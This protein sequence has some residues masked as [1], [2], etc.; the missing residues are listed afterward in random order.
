MKRVYVLG[1]QEI[2]RC[3]E[4]YGFSFEFTEDGAL[5]VWHKRIPFTAEEFFAPVTFVVNEEDSNA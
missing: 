3:A 4:T 2:M 1:V 5:S